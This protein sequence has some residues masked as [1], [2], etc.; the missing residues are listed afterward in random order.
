[1]KIAEPMQRSCRREVQ[2]GLFS[3]SP[4]SL[5]GQRTPAMLFR[6]PSKSIHPIASAKT[7]LE[8]VAGGGPHIGLRLCQRLRINTGPTSSISAAGPNASTS[9]D[10]LRSPRTWPS[11]MRPPL[12]SGCPSPWVKGKEGKEG[13]AAPLLGRQ[14]GDLNW[15]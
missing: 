11:N 15:R 10:D 2:V 6:Q 8:T 14:T 3:V 1:M 5:D 13:E 9:I 7:P 4:F 12:P